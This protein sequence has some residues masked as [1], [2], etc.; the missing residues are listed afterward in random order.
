MAFELKSLPAQEAE[1]LN[2]FPQLEKALP[3]PPGNARM[4]VAVTTFFSTHAAPNVNY[5]HN[6]IQSHKTSI[7]N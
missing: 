3:E 6:K 7:A 4:E 5:L 1:T 2:P